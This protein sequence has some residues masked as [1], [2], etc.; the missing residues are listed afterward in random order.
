M[1]IFCS[2]DIGAQLSLHDERLKAERAFSTRAGDWIS[3]VFYVNDYYE[4]RSKI[5]DYEKD[6]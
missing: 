6:A 3:Q 1:H 2:S 4:S 5:F